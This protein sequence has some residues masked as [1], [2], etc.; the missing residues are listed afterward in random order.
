M[1]NFLVITHKGLLLLKVIMEAE[2]DIAKYIKEEVSFLNTFSI[3]I[4][5]IVQEQGFGHM[6][7]FL[8]G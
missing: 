2:E 8:P 7:K 3:K 1:P 4:A 5:E 6:G